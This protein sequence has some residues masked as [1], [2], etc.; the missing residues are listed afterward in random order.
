MVLATD[1]VQ[2]RAL[3][4]Q[5]DLLSFFVPNRIN[6]WSEFVPSLWRENDWEPSAAYIGNVLL[7]TGICAIPI[8]KARPYLLIAAIGFVLGLGYTV[9][10][11]AYR[12]RRRPSL[13]NQAT[14]A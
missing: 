8:R 4:K 12:D 14:A 9:R 1:T 5:A 3:L 10:I 6:A 2:Q 7:L 11:E 13:L